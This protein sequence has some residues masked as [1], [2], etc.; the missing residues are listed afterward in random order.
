MSDTLVKDDD[1]KDIDR[2]APASNDVITRLIISAILVLAIACLAFF[3]RNA[4]AN[5]TKIE[6]QLLIH[7]NIEFESGEKLVLELDE[8]KA[9]ER[10]S[11]TTHSPWLPGAVTFTGVRVST[12][13]N[14]IGAKSAKFEAIALDDYRFVVD[15]V[16]FDKY[17]VILAYE[18][19]GKPMTVRELGPLWIMFPFDDY[20][21]LLNEKNK[22][23]AVWQ[24]LEM[25]ML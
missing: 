7:G 10:T 12:L 17:P 3:A 16:D 22:G 4:D 5:Q 18:R 20:P 25:V 11:I 2:G 15:G 13:L 6:G 21:E 9:M 14:H 23:A 24:L 8:I 1:H 19:D